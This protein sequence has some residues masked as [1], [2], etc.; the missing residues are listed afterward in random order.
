M[1]LYDNNL[2]VLLEDLLA[3]Y[4]AEKQELES[5]IQQTQKQLVAAK[6]GASILQGGQTRSRKPRGINRTAIV[7]LFRAD[8]TLVIGQA[9]VASRVDIPPSSAA[10]S[11]KQLAKQGLLKQN[12]GLWSLAGSGNDLLNMKGT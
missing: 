1:A 4:M 10:A 6:R 5:K 3:R 12:D 7:D 11:L 9:E 2:V 8:T